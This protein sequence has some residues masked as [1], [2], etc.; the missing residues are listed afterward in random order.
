MTSASRRNLLIGAIASAL[1]MLTAAISARAQ[2]PLKV[3]LLTVRSG[4][5]A[6][7]GA[8]TE[9][10]FKVFLE[11]RSNVVGGREVKLFVADTTGNPAV[12]RTKTQELIERDGVE[13]MIG[14]AFAFEALAIDGLIRNARVPSLAGAGG[15]DLTQRKVNPWFVR[16][17]SSS[18]QVAHPFGEYAYKTMGYRKVVTIGDDTAYQHEFFAGF[19]RTFEE[20]GGEVI[21]KIWAPLGS[22]DYAGAIASISGDANAV[23]ALFTGANAL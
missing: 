19:A 11:Q 3:G 23:V 1:L 17:S 6:G 13:V 5:L 8:Q 12:A 20:A 16:V 15:E 7:T 22:A 14:A 10:G 18:A 9:A 21:Q 2:E 4:P